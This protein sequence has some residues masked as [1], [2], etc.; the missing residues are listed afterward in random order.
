MSLNYEEIEALVAVVETGSF[1]AAGEKLHKAQS[2]IS[3]SIKKIETDLKIK[4][5]NRDGQRTVLTEAGKVVYNKALAIQKINREIN[6]FTNSLADG[7]ESKINLVASAICPTPVLMEI[8]K[9]FNSEFPQTSIELKFITY[10]DPTELLVTADADIVISSY[11]TPVEQTERF[12]WNKIEFV[13]VALAG[14]QATSPD[15]TEEDL[16]NF[17]YLVVGGRETLAKKMPRSQVENLNVWHITDFLIKKEL[18]INGLGWGFMPKQ[19]I[20][21]ELTEGQLVKVPAKL[22]LM[23]ELDIIRKR[24]CYHGKASQYL[25]QLLLKYCNNINPK[26][27][28]INFAKAKVAWENVV[29]IQVTP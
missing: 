11:K 5:F 13:P 18:L 2:S 20:Q 6:S 1:R 16:H 29:G 12:K 8:F 26:P 22:S 19:I 3:Y 17:T 25:W 23:K 4:I 21:R 7:V 24:S 27:K 15:L 10:E 9:E 28:P 14:H